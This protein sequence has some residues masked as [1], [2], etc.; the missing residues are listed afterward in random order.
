VKKLT[1]PLTTVA[2]VKQEYLLENI[3]KI[4]NFLKIKTGNPDGK[5]AC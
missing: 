4:D 5:K 3:E 1:N 2:T